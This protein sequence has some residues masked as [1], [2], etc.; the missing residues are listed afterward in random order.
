MDVATPEEDEARNTAHWATVPGDMEELAAQCC[1][2][3]HGEIGTFQ[4]LDCDRGRWL[5]LAEFLWGLGA[6]PMSRGR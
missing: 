3:F 1:D 5:R 6:R 4:D 2:E